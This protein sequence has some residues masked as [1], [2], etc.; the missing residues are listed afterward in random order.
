MTSGT[1]GTAGTI[2]TVCTVFAISTAGTVGTILIAIRV[3]F[4]NA[5]TLTVWNE[6]GAQEGKHKYNGF[7]HGTNKMFVVLLLKFRLQ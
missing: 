6:E 2:A 1:I 3:P 4:H 7:L 5:T